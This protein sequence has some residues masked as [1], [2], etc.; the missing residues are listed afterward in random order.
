[1]TKKSN[2]IFKVT[3]ENRKKPKEPFVY[4]F[5][6]NGKVVALSESTSE[7]IEYINS[8]IEFEKTLRES[9]GVPSFIGFDTNYEEAFFSLCKMT[10]SEPPFDEDA[11]GEPVEYKVE[12]LV[13]N[14]WQEWPEDDER[15]HILY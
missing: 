13:D 5:L 9:W 10:N 15:L 1:M 4:G 2:V 6:E 11:D 3:K 12:S 7:E 14:P 8:N